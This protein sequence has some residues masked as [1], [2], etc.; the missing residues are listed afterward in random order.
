VMAARRAHHAEAARTS[1]P[2]RSP[3]LPGGPPWYVPCVVVDVAAG[4]SRRF[5]VLSELPPLSLSFCRPSPSNSGSLR[6]FGPWFDPVGAHQ[7]PGRGPNLA[8]TAFWSLVAHA[9][10][11]RRYVFQGFI[12]D[13]AT[14]VPLLGFLI[15]CFVPFT[16]RC[17]C[18]VVGKV[19][20]LGRRRPPRCLVPPEQA[21]DRQVLALIPDPDKD[22]FTPVKVHFHPPPRGC[23][24]PN[25]VSK[26]GRNV[27]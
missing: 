20:F 10:E 25:H 3:S 14:A 8:A 17:S 7:P 9:T 23:K 22:I 13:H 18:N 2:R 19:A 21:Q 12:V 5:V 27:L 16:R 4:A 24:C 1:T 26:G 11:P 15:R 6:L